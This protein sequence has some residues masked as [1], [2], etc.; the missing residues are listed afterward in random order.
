MTLFVGGPYHGKDLPMAQTPGD[1]RLPPV[2]E[3]DEYLDEERQRPGVTA[4]MDWPH[5]YKLDRST[6]PPFYRFVP[7]K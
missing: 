4:K 1:I 5:L 7:D 6:N 2:G 3:V